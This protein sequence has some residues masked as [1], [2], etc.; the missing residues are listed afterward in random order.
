MHVFIS[1]HFIA[2]L[3]KAELYDLT[4]TIIPV[5]AYRRSLGHAEEKVVSVGRMEENPA[6]PPPPH[7]PSPREHSQSGSVSAAVQLSFISLTSGIIQTGQS[8]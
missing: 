2:F 5:S 4:T 7:V 6:P 3:V 8:R 1:D